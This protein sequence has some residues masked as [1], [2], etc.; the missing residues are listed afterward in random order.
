MKL[1]NSPEKDWNCEKKAMAQAGVRLTT[2][3]K[4]GQLDSQKLNIV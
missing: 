3:E 4:G 2:H 1:E